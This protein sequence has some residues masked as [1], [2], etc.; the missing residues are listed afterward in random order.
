MTETLKENIKEVRLSKRL[1]ESPVCLVSGEHDPSAFLEKILS[2]HQKEK[3]QAVKR[4][5]EIN[6]H[7]QIFNKMLKAN[8]EVQEQWADILY[9]QA[10]LTEGSSIKDPIRFSQLLNKLMLNV[11][12]I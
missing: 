3:H 8:K 6:P 5:L 2:S 7:H 10:L 11:D 4:I 9:N 12:S 1:K